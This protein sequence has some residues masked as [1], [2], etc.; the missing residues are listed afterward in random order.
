MTYSFR[1]ATLPNGLTVLA[2]IDPDAH[3][4][5]AG[6]FVRTGARDEASPVMGVSHFLE[7]MMFKGTADLDADAINRGFDELGARNNAYT[8]HE[9][10]CF[11]ASTLPEHL[12]TATDLLGKMMR[13]ALRQADFDTEKQV[14]L[15]EIAMYRDNP[16]FVLYERVMEDRYAGHGMGHRVLGTDATIGALTSEQMRAYFEDRY[17]ADN[18]AVALSGRVDF[19]AAIDQLG[20]LCGAW[21]PTTPARDQARPR[22]VA[23]ELTVRDEKISRGYLVWMADAPPVESLDRYPAGVAMQLLGASNNSRLHWALLETGI[24]DE[25]TAAYDAHAGSGDFFVYAS[26][27]PAKLDQIAGVIDAECRT[28]ADTATDDDLE[29]VR[30]RVATAATLG[31]E[32]PADRMQR[33]GRL[34]ATTGVYTTLDE[35][36]ARINAVTLADVR[37]VLA[38]WPLSRRMAGR[39]IPA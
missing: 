32:R 10:T 24:A 34:W 37:R 30:N 25:A 21:L 29:R 15:E 39:L 18:T 2:E 14:I 27:D 6:F 5:A 1:H 11:Y 31:G 8:S 12:P 16:F 4:A 35:E 13:P 3:T 36:L 38:D 22:T 7:H 26:G 33:L 17:S 9:L 19:D 20:A 28:L 23:G